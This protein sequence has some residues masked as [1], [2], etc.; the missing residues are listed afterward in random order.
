MNKTE[1]DQRILDL[2][3]GSLDADADAKWEL[4]QE[5]MA[6]AELMQRYLEFARLENMLHLKNEGM[7]RVNTPAIPVDFILSQQKKTALRVALIGA[8][9]MIMITAVLMKLFWVEPSKALLA[10]RVSEH[11]E[12]VLIHA[13]EDRTFEAATLEEG[14]AMHVT[15]G[16]VELT[17]N[18]GVTSIIT[19]PAHFTLLNEN[20]LHLENGIAWFQ[21]PEGAEG[22][23]VVTADAEV[24]DLGT[25]FGVE[26]SNDQLGEVHV[27]QGTVSVTRQ[28]DEESEEILVEGDARLSN[29]IGVLQKIALEKEKFISVFPEK[30]KPQ[31]VF[32]EQFNAGY[33]E[34]SS[35]GSLKY[36]IGDFGMQW[37]HE[38]G[39]C[40]INVAGESDHS[41][42]SFNAYGEEVAADGEGYVSIGSQSDPGSKIIRKIQVYRGLSYRVYFRYAGSHS[43]QNRV[44][45]TFSLAGESATTGVLRAP[46][47]EWESGSL[48][49]TPQQSGLAELVFDDW[50]TIVPNTSDLLLDSV[51]VTAVPVKKAMK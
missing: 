8:A 27:F 51:V 9:A 42:V 11:S 37:N 4:Q 1:I 40:S 22:F 17:F 31:V 35:V 21:V 32:V 19:A 20:R 26:V 7:A 43:D 46:K 29:E 48:V 25:E 33:S 30:G 50:E 38:K 49:F 34:W 45:G 47:Q 15:T 13:G 16:V 14:S 23:T 3:D 24:V 5:L 36:E 39:S 44:T 41:I 10:F 6:D 2:L 18:N 28:K 12:F